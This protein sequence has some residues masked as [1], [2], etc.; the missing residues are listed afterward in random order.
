MNCDLYQ[1]VRRV[2]VARTI[3]R[4]ELIKGLLATGPLAVLIV[5]DGGS[6]KG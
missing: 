4:R 5:G 2:G 1:A 3:P 6:G